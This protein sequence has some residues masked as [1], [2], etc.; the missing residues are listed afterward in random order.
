MCYEIGQL[1]VLLTRLG[2]A[3]LDVPAA[4]FGNWLTIIDL[5]YNIF[6]IYREP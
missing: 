2:D 4:L 6:V 5:L 3:R 1:R